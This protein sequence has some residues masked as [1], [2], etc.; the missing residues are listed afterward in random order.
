MRPGASCGFLWRSSGLPGRPGAFR[1]G[2]PLRTQGLGFKG[3]PQRAEGLGFRVIYNYI[4]TPSGVCT[5]RQQ[6][7]L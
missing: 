4:E 3:A 6:I 7:S 1:E 2:S 5:A